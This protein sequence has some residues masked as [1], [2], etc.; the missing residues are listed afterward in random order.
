MAHKL[1]EGPAFSAIII[2]GG[3]GFLIWQKS[4]NSLYSLTGGLILGIL[5]YTL[6]ILLSKRKPK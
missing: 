3:V 5:D 1:Q 6:L 2:A 4:Q